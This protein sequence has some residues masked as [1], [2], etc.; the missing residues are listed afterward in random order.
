MADDALTLD[1]AKVTC[2]DAIT[3]RETFGSEIEPFLARMLEKSPRSAADRGVL[4]WL[5]AR[6]NGDPLC[7]V[8][9]VAASVPALVADGEDD[10]GASVPAPDPAPVN[11][12]ETA[13][14]AV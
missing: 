11:P 4:A 3:Y 14:V 7:A 1:F 10:A 6:Q 12:P 8:A 13:E 2:W 5:Y 9:A